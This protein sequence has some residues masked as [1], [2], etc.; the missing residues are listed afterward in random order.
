MV[1]RN[2]CPE[3]GRTLSYI[4]DNDNP[5]C[6]YCGEM[7]SSEAVLSEGTIKYFVCPE[8]DKYY[9]IPESSHNPKYCR[10]CPGVELELAVEA[11][12]PHLPK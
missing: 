7:I 1:T 9:G 10:V 3:C 2:T 4:P 11:L 5:G 12:S 8:C 6:E